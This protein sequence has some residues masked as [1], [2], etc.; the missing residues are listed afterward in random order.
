M[1]KVSTKKIC[2]FTEKYAKLFEKLLTLTKKLN[3]LKTAKVVKKDS[4]PYDQQKRS[5]WK[6]NECERR[7][8]KSERLREFSF[9]LFVNKNMK[10]K[11]GLIQ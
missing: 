6:E 5:C 11:A 2:K 8:A 1:S 4:L 3:L 9:K 7:D 10:T